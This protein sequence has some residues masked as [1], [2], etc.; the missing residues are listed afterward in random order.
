MH[1]RLPSKIYTDRASLPLDMA[2]AVAAAAELRA[3]DE[4]AQSMHWGDSH[5]ALKAAKAEI[6]ERHGLA[7][8]KK[9]PEGKARVMV[10]W[11]WPI[12]KAG[13][14]KDLP[15]VELPKDFDYQCNLP[16]LTGIDG[17]WLMATTG[18]NST[19]RRFVCKV[20]EAHD[21]VARVVAGKDDDAGCY[22]QAANVSPAPAPEPKPAAPKPPPKQATPKPSAPKSPKRAA[23]SAQGDE[24]KDDEEPP[25]SGR[26][27]RAKKGGPSE[28][29]P[30]P[31]AADKG[32]KNKTKSARQAAAL[33]KG[34]PREARRRA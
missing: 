8:K 14:R 26:P 13:G 16:K 29:E 10:A 31:A 15:D 12:G 20:D 11:G 19:Q 30:A 23:P 1:M 22:L 5:P 17:R 32:N 4:V 25:S 7:K 2:G 34:P 6:L 33:A 18:N 27:K 24:A 9:D 3:L 21:Y 28:A